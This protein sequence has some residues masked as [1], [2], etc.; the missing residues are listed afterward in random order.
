MNHS[1]KQFVLVNQKQHDLCNLIPK[2]MILMCLHF[3]VNQKHTALQVSSDLNQDYTVKSEFQIAFM[4]WFF[5][6]NQKTFLPL[7]VLLVNTM[8]SEFKINSN[9]FYEQILFSESKM[10]SMASVDRF[11]KKMLLWIGSLLIKNIKWD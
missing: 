11:L 10:Y 1:D 6:V 3:L 4:N 5:L 8:C 2:H 7:Q 9:R